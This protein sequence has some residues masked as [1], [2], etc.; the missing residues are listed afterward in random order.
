MRLGWDWVL[1]VV[2]ALACM[3]VVDAPLLL[4][5]GVLMIK[6]IGL[7]LGC[8]CDTNLL[9]GVRLCFRDTLLTVV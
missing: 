2:S 3:H 1:S 9:K 5:H 8:Y 4:L 7:C 6:C